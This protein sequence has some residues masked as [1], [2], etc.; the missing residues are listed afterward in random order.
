[1]TCSEAGMTAM[2]DIVTGANAA[3]PGLIEQ[4]PAALATATTAAEVLDAKSKA[5]FAYTTA[6]AAA[7]FAE[8]K[9]A[10]DTVVTACR[11]RVVTEPD[12][13]V[14]SFKNALVGHNEGRLLDLMDPVEK[15]RRLHRRKHVLPPTAD[16]A[17][18]HR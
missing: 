16:V 10:H 12:T 3:L 15:D 14:E 5:G 13:A 18:G 6:K 2:N 4:A 8:A 7:R 17:D 1:M 9:N 11:K